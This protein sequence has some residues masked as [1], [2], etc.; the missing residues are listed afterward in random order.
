MHHA[1]TNSWVSENSASLVSTVPQ[2][3]SFSVAVNVL[4]SILVRSVI[5]KIDPIL[6]SYISWTLLFSATAA[7]GTYVALA[8]KFFHPYWHEIA[9]ES[10]KNAIPFT[11]EYMAYQHVYV[12][13]GSK[14][15]VYFI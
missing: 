8:V 2:G 10:M 14:S 11:N 5:V 12:H 9:N 3:L 4:W 1:N 15:N 6:N 7:A 13:H